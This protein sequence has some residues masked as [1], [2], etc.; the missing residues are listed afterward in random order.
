MADFEQTGGWVKVHWR[1]RSATARLTVGRFFIMIG[2]FSGRLTAIWAFAGFTWPL[3]DAD[4]QRG[5][6]KWLI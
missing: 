3:A 6:A 2:G 1:A 5:S 4:R